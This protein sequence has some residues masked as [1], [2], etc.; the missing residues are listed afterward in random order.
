MQS[1]KK[2]DLVSLSTIPLI[3][4]LGNSMLIPVLPSIREK[5]G[6][7]SLQV[8]LIITIYS[9][10]AIVLI[11]IAG[12]L[13]DR[14]GRK[15]IIIPSLIVTAAGGLVCGLGAW[16]LQQS[17]M[18]ILIGR[19]LQGIGAAGAAPIVMPLVGDLF[20]KES[21]VSTGLGIIETSNTFGKV[22]SP[23]LGSILAAWIWFVPFLAIPVL[24][25]ISL[26]MV[27]FL[28]KTPAREEE[29]KQTIGQF[30]QTVKTIFTEKGRW[31]YAIFAI[32]GICMFVVFAALF[33]LSDLLED[34]YGI[35]GVY[36]GLLLA[37]PLAMLCLSSF[38]TGKAIG[39]NKTRMK[40]ADFIG[41]LLLTGGMFLCGLI[42]TGTL[43][44]LFLF[45]SISG[46]G[47]GMALPSLDAL[48]T[49]GIEKGQRGTVT[50]L[51]SSMRFIGVAVGPP[52]ASVL[53]GYSHTVLFYSIGGACALAALLA[54]SAIKPGPSRVPQPGT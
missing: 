47:I 38:V 41:T 3:M 7:S 4:T 23:I 49:E 50:S 35:H 37:I 48:I 45:I 18:V 36:K 52:V 44:M 14:F 8:S 16:F 53:E 13:S 15:K 20:K 54:L 29:P 11:P 9:M 32:G 43:F 10:V 19:F 30:L 22:V 40:W 25:L 33:F 42:H 24:C 31:L 6:V 28:V 2:W 17:Y 5:L 1:D 12:Y 26:L 39:E 46:I 51:Y 21:D 27:S 34:Q